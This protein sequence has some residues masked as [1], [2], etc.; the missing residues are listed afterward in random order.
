MLSATQQYIINKVNE[1]GCK[2][3]ESVPEYKNCK[4]SYE[5]KC[6]QTFT[7]IFK[8]FERRNCRSCNS[9]KLK[10][11]PLEE[12]ES[13]V[14]EES[15]E[16]W[17]PI[18]GGWISSFGNAK[19]SVGRPLKLCETKFRY[20][21]A[22][23][24]QYASILVAEAFQ[25]ENIDKLKKESYV[26]MH[27]DQNPSNNKLDNLKI[28]HKETIG[29]INGKKSRQSDIFQEKTTWKRSKFDHLES[30]KIPEL[31]RHVIYSNGEIWSGN[32]FLTF[33]KTDGYKT[34]RV[35]IQNYKAH[36]IICYAFNP[37]EGKNRFSDYSN[38]QVNHKNGDKTDNNFEN[39]EWVDNRYNMIHAYT[40]GLN[41]K[42]NH[43]VQLDKVT[44]Q[45]LKKYNSVAHASRETGEPEHRISCCANGK[46]N[47]MMIYLWAY[48]DDKNYYV[49][50]G[51]EKVAVPFTN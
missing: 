44:K 5:C 39:L 19:N 10:N 26:V 4:I 3:I 17:K 7:R 20:Y 28:V 8:D 37:L 16:I 11:K 18:E 47:S 49:Y 31:P 9:V 48:C 32:N 13:K 21:M 42:V 24:Q 43:V 34:F 38:L 35:G 1:K 40:T 41:N 27:I 50:E 14:D 22:G 36:R 15:G 6:G 30:R 25:I 45:V 33:S 51:E 23:K 29:E 2:L 12:N 46:K